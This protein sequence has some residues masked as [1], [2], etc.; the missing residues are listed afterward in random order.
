MR[1][2]LIFTPEARAQIE[3]LEDAPAKAKV[4][5]AVRK[6]LGLM[7]T[8]LRHPGLNT[9]KFASLRGAA[10]EE[11]FEAYAQN[12]TPGAFRIFWHYG[13]GKG[14]LTILSVTPHP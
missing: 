14:H 2:E 3:A 11:V 13:P 1:F 9:H 6:T 7:E 12:L 10:G 4:L 5:K 8:N